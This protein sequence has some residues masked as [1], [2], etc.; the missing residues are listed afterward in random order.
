MAAQ[1]S[2]ARFG[3]IQR[4]GRGGEEDGLPNRRSDT[5]VSIRATGGHTRIAALSRNFCNGIFLF[6]SKR[7]TFTRRGAGWCP[8]R[9]PQTHGDL[10]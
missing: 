3:M 4:R 8:R 5:R 2:R 9:R 10:I 1:R 7:A 6:K